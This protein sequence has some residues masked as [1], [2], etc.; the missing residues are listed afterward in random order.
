[1]FAKPFGR[2]AASS[3]FWGVNVMACECSVGS[4]TGPR[5][6]G[7]RPPA[8]VSPALPTGAAV[9]ADPVRPTAPAGP[10]PEPAH[11]AA[12]D[13]RPAHTP[14]RSVSGPSRSLGQGTGPGRSRPHR[15]PC[16]L[17]TI[18]ATR[19]PYGTSRRTPREPTEVA[20]ERHDRRVMFQREPREMRVR[21]QVAARSRS[22]EQACEQFE[23]TSSRRHHDGRGSA[24]ASR[25]SRWS[26]PER[27]AGAANT[28]ECVETRTNAR[29][30]THAK[31]TASDSGERGVDP[32][33]CRH[34]ASARRC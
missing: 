13:R 20:I 31:P 28:D 33:L 26:L 5:A 15:W 4:G 11:F 12:G 23:V 1:M 22:G 8:A 19:E 14:P 29:I 17:P 7:R 18:E 21:D 34:V 27:P 3:A 16:R 32:A 10:R 6:C 30:V 2:W 9:R 24:R 25:A